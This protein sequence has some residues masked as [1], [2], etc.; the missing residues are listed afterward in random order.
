MMPM[1]WLAISMHDTIVGLSPHVVIPS[2]MRI[3]GHYIIIVVELM[4][5]VAINIGLDYA[6]EKLNIPFLGTLLSSFFG[7]YVW[8]VICRLLG[9]LYFLNRNRLGWF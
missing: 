7:I 2:I 1:A 3:P 8:L 6:L 5:L 4:V 9:S